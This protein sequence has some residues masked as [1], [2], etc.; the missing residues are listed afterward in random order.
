MFLF[1]LL[2]ATDFTEQKLRSACCEEEV[3]S[4]TMCT[5][6]CLCSNLLALFLGVF[7]KS[8]TTDRSK[9]RKKETINPLNQ[10]WKLTKN[11]VPVEIVMFLYNTS[12]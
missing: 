3:F 12:S 1:L 6:K 9:K 2:P 8:E 11:G 5:A 4:F 7:K 10:D